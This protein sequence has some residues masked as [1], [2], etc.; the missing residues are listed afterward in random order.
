MLRSIGQLKIGGQMGLWTYLTDTQKLFQFQI[1]IEFTAVV[2][3][4]KAKQLGNT[5]LAFC[6]FFVME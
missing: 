1:Q 2:G 3:F 5:I 6:A 4:F